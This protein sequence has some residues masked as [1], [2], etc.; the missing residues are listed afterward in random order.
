M[1]SVAYHFVMVARKKFLASGISGVNGFAGLARRNNYVQ[2]KKYSES[3][4]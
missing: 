3:E 1:V 4:Y 2:K